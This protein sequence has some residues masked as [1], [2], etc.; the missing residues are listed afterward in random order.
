MKFH[1]KPPS[2][3][4]VAIGDMWNVFAQGEIDAGSDERLLQFLRE[5]NVPKRSAIWLNSPGGSLMAGIKLGKVIRDYELFTHIGK[6]ENQR[7]DEIASPGECYSACAIAFLGGTY[8]FYEK[9]SEYGVHRFHSSTKAGND[10]DTAQIISAMIVQYMGDMGV[11]PELFTFMSHAGSTELVRLGRAEMERLHV[12]NGGR[13][14]TKWTLESLAETGTLYLKV[15]ERPGG[16]STNSW[17]YAIRSGARSSSMSY[18][19]Q[20]GAVRKLLKG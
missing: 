20:K 10:S 12:V 17:S 15:R 4:D 1:R 13:S 18:L 7:K 14:P 6:D 5:N 8:R 16:V 9:G 2:V 19:I 11:D 3:I